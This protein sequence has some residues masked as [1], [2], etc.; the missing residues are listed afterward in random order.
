MKESKTIYT[1]PELIMLPTD[2]FDAA[3]EFKPELTYLDLGPGKPKRHIL[4]FRA[5]YLD[6]RSLDPNINSTNELRKVNL[7]SLCT[8]RALL[9][10][11]IT[12]ALLEGHSGLPPFQRIESTLNW[13]DQQKRSA[14]LY[15]IEDAQR[16][17]KDYTNHLRHRMRLSNV[18]SMSESI[19]YAMANSL[20][21]AMAYLCGKACGLDP[22]VIQSWTIRIPQRRM[23][24]NEQPGPATTANEHALAYALHQ[25]FFETFSHAVLNNITPPVVVKLVDLGFEDLIFYS[26]NANNA[27]SW[28]TKVKEGRTDWQP[29]C[30]RPDG[31]FEGTTKEFNALLA[32]HGIA[33]ITTS[34][35][36]KIQQNNRQFSQHALRNLA[37]HA[38]RHFAYLLLAETGGNA[39][40]LATIDFR[41]LK[42]NKA[43]GLVS[44]RAI[45]GRAGFEEQEQLV[46]SRFA[47]KTWKQHLKLHEWMMQQLEAPPELGLFL[48]G[49]R[50]DRE[51]FS[52]LKSS[53]MQILPLW[54]AG[55]PALSSRDAR[56]HKTVNLLEGSNGNIALVSSM[57]FA[58]PQTIERHYA[59][60][61]REEA[62]KIMSDYF[63]A[64][65]KAAELRHLGVKPVRIIEDGKT[66]GA[67]LCDIKEGNPKQI[68]GFEKI[69]IE[70]RCT[71][72]ITCIFCIHFG[73][74][75]DVE[76]ILRLLT[77]KYWVE[78]QSRLNSIN[79][80]EHF[81]KFLPY[82]NRIQQVLDE[83]LKM[84]GEISQHVK[85]AIDQFERGERD[86]YWGAKI[87]ALLDTEEI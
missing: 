35:L 15:K 9:M 12:K 25:R 26:K 40:H 74:H 62:A 30:F 20:Q 49:I 45:K 46:D 3:P 48:L 85:E 81:Q 63:A 65:A 44:T 68:A 17:Y 41:T 59:F 58:T 51:P 50:H 4:T 39:A 22:K 83:L 23:E 71:A 43:I 29:F 77:I 76:D 86:L 32:E 75:A 19:G 47:E 78:V 31:I 79:I 24:L 11:T 87:N 1:L 8:K 57:Q 70:P 53:T 6:R 16:L 42:L 5:C 36:R 61:N 13:I 27:G 21:L 55:A 72:P 66:I 73:L 82:I 7:S 56:K 37:N 69:A 34:A 10:Q 14:E 54:P 67:G 38:T 28:S 64:Q 80:N 33:P 2:R 60:K 18:G 84:E 52:P